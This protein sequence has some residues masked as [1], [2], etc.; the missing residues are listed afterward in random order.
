MKR[1][2]ALL[3]LLLTCENAVF[4][5]VA[6]P[7]FTTSKPVAL[8]AWLSAAPISPTYSQRDSF[9]RP[10]RTIVIVQDEQAQIPHINPFGRTL[11]ETAESL[12]KKNIINNAE[13]TVI[14]YLSNGGAG[15]VNSPFMVSGYDDENESGTRFSSRSLQSAER[16]LAELSER[17]QILKQTHYN[18][19]LLG[20]DQRA[21]SYDAGRLSVPGYALYLDSIVPAATPALQNFISAALIEGSL[22]LP[23][24]ENERAVFIAALSRTLD[25]QETERLARSGKLLRAGL[26]SHADYYRILKDIAAGKDAALGDYPELKLYVQYVE[27]CARIDHDAVFDELDAQEEIVR[28]QLALTDD[29]RQ[30]SA[31]NK[32]YVLMKKLVE[33][34]LSETD[35]KTRFAKARAR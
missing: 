30:I 25:P 5:R 10:A 2:A 19:G 33:R 22:N 21:A 4:A 34:R 29:E 23:R 26:V 8:P 20:F 3:A 18:D 14:G 1:F 32:A 12:L 6:G 17:L 15:S 7:V 31:L 27:L 13:Y 24:A 9:I 16:S 35:G 28:A 11:R